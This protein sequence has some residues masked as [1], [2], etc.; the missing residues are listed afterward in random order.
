MLSDH[1]EIALRPFWK[2]LGTVCSKGLDLLNK[3]L[4]VEKHNKMLFRKNINFV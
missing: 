2:R 3:L 4:G 1:F